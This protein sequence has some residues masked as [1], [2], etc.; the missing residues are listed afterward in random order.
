LGEVSLLTIFIAALKFFRN[1]I[2]LQDEFYNQQMTQGK[3]FEPVLN[4]L[5]ETMPRDNLLNSACLEFFEF[6][7]TNTMKNVMGHL[8][9]NYREKMIE[10]TYVETFQNFISKY[11]NSN[12]F[13][14]NNMETSFLETEG[15]E[16]PKRCETGTR[17]W[18]NGIKEMDA[19]EEE[20]F[21]TSDD[22]DDVVSKSTRSSVNGASPL[23]KPLVDYPSDEETEN[24]ETDA[25][26]AGQD[27]KADESESMGPK[28]L[29]IDHDLPTIGGPRAPERL[30]EK[31]RREEDEEDEI[32]KLSQS[33]R[34]NSS[35]SVGSNT[36]NVLRRKQS[37]AKHGVAAGSKSNKIAISLSTAIKSGG[38]TG[39]E[40]GGS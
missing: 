21:N 5:I 22:E 20:Y 18:E 30:S 1:L 27:S 32:G 34:R 28:E 4:L 10:I 14:P 12:G 7:H 17:R 3:L 24:I 40:E 9:E 35:S 31:R 25:K 15:S 39:G 29:G 16:T 36:S 26:S 23:S 8:V 6:I 11:D 38:D 33:K 13:D 37:F 19:A 2:G